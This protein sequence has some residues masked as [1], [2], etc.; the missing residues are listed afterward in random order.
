ME[1]EYGEIQHPPARKQNVIVV[2]GS[3]LKL[4]LAQREEPQVPAPPSAYSKL[5]AQLRARGLIT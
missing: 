3:P 5:K 2:S 1:D 4:V